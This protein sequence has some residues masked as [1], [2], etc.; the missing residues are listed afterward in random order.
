MEENNRT[1]NKF[2]AAISELNQEKSCT[3]QKMEEMKTQF[4]QLSQETLMY[5][6]QATEPSGQFESQHSR[7]NSPP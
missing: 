1:R 6:Q 7:T 4:H 5:Q 3:Q 2:E